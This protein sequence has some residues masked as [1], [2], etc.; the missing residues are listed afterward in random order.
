MCMC[1]CVCVCTDRQADRQISYKNPLHS[2]DGLVMQEFFEHVALEIDANC[3]DGTVQYV[4]EPVLDRVKEKFQK[5]FSLGRG[6]L[7]NYLDILFFFS[8]TSCLAQV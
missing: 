7:Y 4:F 5:E 3:E 1:V 2:L 8:R 6:I